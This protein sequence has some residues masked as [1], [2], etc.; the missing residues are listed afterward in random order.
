MCCLNFFLSRFFL[1]HFL[2]F[3]LSRSFTSSLSLY[4]TLSLSLFCSF[5]LS[6]FTL[7]RSFSLSFFSLSLF[8]SL[9]LVFS[10]SLSLFHSFSLSLFLPFFISLSISLSLSLSHTHT[11]T[12]CTKIIFM[13]STFFQTPPCF[14][15]FSSKVLNFGDCSIRQIISRAKTADVKGKGLNPAAAADT[16]KE[17]RG[18]DKM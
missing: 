12:I 16:G 2:S 14:H 7:S 13:C 6:L 8:L 5:S 11:H 15:A 4:L 9:S 17:E 3:I 1:Y 10:P 18:L